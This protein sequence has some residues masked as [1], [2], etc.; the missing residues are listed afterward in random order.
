MI[1]R[2]SIS[3]CNR[4]GW[5]IG[6]YRSEV[7]YGISGPLYVPRGGNDINAA[8]EVGA[9]WMNPSPTSANNSTQIKL[10]VQANYRI[11]RVYTYLSFG[12]AS[13]QPNGTWYRS[14]SNLDISNFHGPLSDW[15]G[16]QTAE[17]PLVIYA[18]LDLLT[19]AAAC[20]SP[21]PTR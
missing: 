10:V 7:P 14:G 19:T 16:A 1:S 6:T 17:Q 20:A 9:W 11:S 15:I 8:L 18:E 3:N 21:I 2:T 5:Y 4:W 13:C 12:F